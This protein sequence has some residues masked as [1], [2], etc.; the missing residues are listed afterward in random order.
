MSSTVNIATGKASASALDGAAEIPASGSPSGE[1][2]LRNG[3]VISGGK[4]LTKPVPA[5][6]SVAA[7]AATAI[8]VEKNGRS[9]GSRSRSRG[10][11]HGINSLAGGKVHSNVAAEAGGVHGSA[12]DPSDAGVDPFA[13][14]GT[15]RDKSFGRSSSSSASSKKDARIEGGEVFLSGRRKPTG[16]STIIGSD[17]DGHRGEV[18]LDGFPRHEMFLTGSGATAAPSN[19]TSSSVSSRN[20]FGSGSGSG[21]RRRNSRRTLVEWF[22]DDGD[23]REGEKI[24]GHGVGPSRSRRSSAVVGDVVVAGVGRLGSG[25][26]RRVLGNAEDAVVEAGSRNRA[27][28]KLADWVKGAGVDDSDG[29]TIL[30]G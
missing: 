25:R 6:A 17:N 20:G 9:R 30:S 7:A 16:L 12:N 22:R 1:R 8:A 5:T 11:S 3:T 26:D 10:R 29:D 21:N 27:G 14:N 28:R 23:N 18:A 13:F 15:R 19:E 4:D 2:H 24:G